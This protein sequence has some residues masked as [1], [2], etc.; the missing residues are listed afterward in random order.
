M[1][2]DILGLEF[3]SVFAGA[4][5]LSRWGW[6]GSVETAIAFQT[7]QHSNVQSTTTTPQ[8]GGIIPS[9]QHDNGIF[10]QMRGQEPQLCIGHLDRRCARCYPLLIQDIG[11]A[12]RWL[13]QGHHGRKLP[14]KGDR[15][16]TFGQI[17]DVLSTA[18][19]RGNSIRASYTAGIDSDPEPL[20]SILFWQVLHKDFSQAQ[21]INTTILKGLIQA[22]PLPLKPERLRDAQR[23]DF[24]WAWVIS[25]STVLNKAS[26]A[27]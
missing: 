3:G 18:I 13:R 25:A 15:F 19:R 1:G 9:I 27:R 10:R 4:S 24:A 8:P 21:L 5:T 23:N 14:A 7:T 6:S 17:W 12:T 22:R 26:L 11:P 16:L 20:A 2:R